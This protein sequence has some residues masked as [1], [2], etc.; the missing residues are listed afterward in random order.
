METFVIALNE[1]N[2]NVL[3]R[4]EEAYPDNYRLSDTAFLVADNTL[5]KTIAEAV[6]IN[7]KNRIDTA[8]GVVFKLNKAYSGY[9]EP[10]LWERLQN[11]GEAQ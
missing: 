5:T 1:T 6:G 4:I 9:S 7:G 8:L 10:S 11:K 3:K 2:P